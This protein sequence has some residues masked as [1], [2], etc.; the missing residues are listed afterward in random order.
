LVHESLVSEILEY[1]VRCE[2]QGEAAKEKKDDQI[3]HDIIPY[4]S[5]PVWKKRYKNVAIPTFFS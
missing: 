5:E 4:L 3:E 2:K 1:G